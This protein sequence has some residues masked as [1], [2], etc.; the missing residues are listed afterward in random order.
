M[1]ERA[2]THAYAD[3]N[4]NGHTNT[5]TNI[6]ADTNAESRLPDNFGATQRGINR[7][8]YRGYFDS[9]GQRRRHTLVSM[10]PRRQR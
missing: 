7:E 1:Q 5:L 4:A 10:V 6:D 2:N 8:W 3:T 9:R